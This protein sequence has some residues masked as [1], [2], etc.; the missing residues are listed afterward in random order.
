MEVKDVIEQARESLTVK[1]VFGE[2][3]GKDGVTMIPVARV[4][5][6]AAGEEARPPKDREKAPEVASG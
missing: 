1:R 2:P 4:Q 6:V 3:Y 5:V